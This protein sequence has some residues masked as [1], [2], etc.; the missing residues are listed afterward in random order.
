MQSSDIAVVSALSLSLLLLAGCSGS[1]RAGNH[2]LAAPALTRED[3][4]SRRAPVNPNAPYAV[5][6]RRGETPALPSTATGAEIATDAPLCSFSNLGVSEIS[7]SSTS[8]ERTVS[9]AFINRGDSACKLSGYPYIAAPSEDSLGIKSLT[10]LHE[11][12]STEANA[13]EVVLPPKGSASFS[14]KWTTGDSCPMISTLLVTAPGTNQSFSLNR[15]VSPCH[16]RV[17]ISAIHPIPT[18]GL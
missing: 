10:V 13:A 6:K 18:T 14:L 3:P 5:L 2:A 15:P 1:A 8:E 11:E 4:H 9:I 12:G 16:G 17:E 7:A